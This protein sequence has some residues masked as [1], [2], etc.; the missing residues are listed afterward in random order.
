MRYCAVCSTRIH[1][2]GYYCSIHKPSYRRSRTQEMYNYNSD[3][4]YPSDTHYRTSH[5]TTG[6]VALR[7]P[8][9]DSGY[10][11]ALYNHHNVPAINTPLAHTLVQSFAALQDTHVIASLTYSVARDG[12]QTLTA[13]ANL[14]R[15]QCPVCYIWFANHQQLVNHQW[16]CP[17]GCEAHR[18]CMREEDAVWH[19]TTERHDRCFVRNCASVYR[20][21]GGW[22][23]LFVE[24]HVRAQH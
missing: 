15:E 10:N 11:L 5:G 4:T 7:R 22:K 6:T 21:E 20:R 3:S 19:A 13:E 12:T 9:R 14:E 18:T 16:E 23:R 1:G 24:E 2:S 8:N 17:V